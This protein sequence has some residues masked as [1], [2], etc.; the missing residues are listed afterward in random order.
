[1]ILTLN[2]GHYSIAP[3]GT[4]VEK[5]PITFIFDKGMPN[6]PC[7]FERVAKL[8]RIVNIQDIIISGANGKGKAKTS[9]SSKL[10]TSCTAVTYKFVEPVA[11]K[12]PVKIGRKKRKKK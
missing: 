6:Q 11:K 9:D 2:R 4:K 10:K 8:S 3:D 12:K 5:P 1:M 7:G